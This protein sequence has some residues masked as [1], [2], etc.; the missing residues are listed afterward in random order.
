MMLNIGSPHFSTCSKA[1]LLS[2]LSPSFR[3]K[4]VPSAQDNYS[5][6]NGNLH[7]NSLRKQ[8]SPSKLS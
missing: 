6:S 3:N 1:E 5:Q 8:S 2:R 7:K 4:R